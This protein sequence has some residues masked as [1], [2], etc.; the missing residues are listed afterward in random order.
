MPE[1]TRTYQTDLDDLAY[2]ISRSEAF[3]E[4]RRALDSTEID[5]QQAQS[6]LLDLVQ[7]GK[8]TV[9]GDHGREIFRWALSEVEAGRLTSLLY[10]H[11]LG[12]D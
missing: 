7:C 10:R 5:D 12:A 4:I 11:Y 6:G 2:Q 3:G 1:I 8:C 9:A